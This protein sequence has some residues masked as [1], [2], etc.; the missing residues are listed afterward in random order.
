MII[1]TR[2]LRCD[3]LLQLAPSSPDMDLIE[4][5][6]AE[7]KT[8]IKQHRHNHVDFFERDFETFLRMRVGRVFCW[9]EAIGNCQV[10]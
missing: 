10:L 4:E 3:R 6:F 8:H 9:E 2:L 7:I 5:L 1:E